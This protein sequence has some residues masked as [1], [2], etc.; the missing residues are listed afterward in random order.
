M[1]DRC[2][3]HKVYPIILIRWKL[4]IKA[5]FFLVL[6]SKNSLAGRTT[7]LI[8]KVDFLQTASISDKEEQTTA[9]DRWTQDLYLT[10]EEEWSD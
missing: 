4:I 1:E 6:L 10:P 9:T 7:Y 8:K 3:A 5:V 2:Q